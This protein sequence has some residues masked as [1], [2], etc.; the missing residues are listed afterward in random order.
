MHYGDNE[1]IL[2]NELI[3]IIYKHVT[4]KKNIFDYE[5]ASIQKCNYF[6]P[7]LLKNLLIKPN[8]FLKKQF[9]ELKSEEWY[10]IFIKE[11]ENSEIVIVSTTNVS[12]SENEFHKLH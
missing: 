11:N 5:I 3:I 7:R 2:E 1:Q 12:H 8:K 9:K 4:E 6:S 10:E